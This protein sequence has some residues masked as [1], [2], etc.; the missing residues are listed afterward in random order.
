MKIFEN[1][2][3]ISPYRV[4]FTRRL[5]K[6]YKQI[7]TE[8][9]KAIVL[10]PYSTIDELFNFNKDNTL[11]ELTNDIFNDFKE[12]II[13]QE[14]INNIC[15]TINERLNS[16]LLEPNQDFD[17]ITKLLFNLEK[18]F[19]FEKGFTNWLSLIDKYLPKRIDI[20]LV[21][22]ERIEIPN[23]RNIDLLI[24]TDRIQKQIN[25]SNLESLIIDN[26]KHNSIF[27]VEDHEKLINW[28]EL[29]SKMAF[30]NKQI[31]DYFNGIKN[32]DSY[33]IENSFD[34]ICE[35]DL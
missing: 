8:N 12:R 15:E 24:V 32:F 35:I 30:S 26:H 2:V 9:P 28:I 5:F 6:I 19:M 18:Q 34:K 27:V 31:S 10:T 23:L 21:G 22:F 16:N 29:T 3:D 13:N 33:I 20:V 1:K 17:K 11:L 25:Y 14:Y 4:L 7:I